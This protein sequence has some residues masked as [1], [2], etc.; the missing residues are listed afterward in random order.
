MDLNLAYLNPSKECALEAN[1]EFPLDKTMLMAK[2]V[3]DIN[4]RTI[5]AQVRDKAKAQERYEDAV[6]AGNTA[7][8]A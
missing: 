5:E 4:G 8:L 2:L 3:A 1:Y 7:V 6:A